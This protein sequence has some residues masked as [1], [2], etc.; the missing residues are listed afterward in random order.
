MTIKLKLFTIY[1]GK[2]VGLLFGQMVSKF[3]D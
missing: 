3:Q 2:P 1:K